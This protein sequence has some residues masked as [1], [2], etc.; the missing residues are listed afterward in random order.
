MKKHF[1][2][3]ASQL[4]ILA[5]TLLAAPAF[6]QVPQDMTYTGRL[7][8]NLGDPLAGPSAGVFLHASVLLNRMPIIGHC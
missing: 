8:D 4:A 5:L 7:V 6:A 2:S 3:F 1:Q